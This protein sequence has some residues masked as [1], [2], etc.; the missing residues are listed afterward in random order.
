MIRLA[1]HI[2]KVL[3]MLA[4]LSEPVCA[5]D[6]R[7]SGKSEFGDNPFVATGF[8]KEAGVITGYLSAIRIAPG[9]TD[10]CRF[11]FA[12]NLK[13]SHVLRIRYIFG[14]EEIWSESGTL[15]K[16]VMK[17]SP[18]D[19]TIILKKGSLQADCEW[20]L[21]FIGEPRIHERGDELSIAV[22]KRTAG[23]WTGVYL[24]SA[25]RARFHDSPADSASGKAFLVAGDVIYVYEERPGWYYVK[26]DGRKKQTV[27]WIK[28]SD[29]VQISN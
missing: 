27:G 19:A 28:K 14:S 12:G 5:L 4:V 24:I 9:R 23:D 1:K 7:T 18:E 11:L 3:F 13:Q 8:N 2:F 29:T 15:S 22:K 17:V 25:P 26:Y 20:I 16:A 10:E 21:P 6:I